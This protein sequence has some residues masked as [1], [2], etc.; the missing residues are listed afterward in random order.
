MKEEA[1]AARILYRD[2]D[3]LVIDKPAGLPVHPGPKTV[4]DLES[5]LPILRFDSRHVPALAH[6]LDTDTSGCLVLARSPKALKRLA[7]AFEAKTI[8][9]RYW[10]IVEGGP[11]EEAGR[12]DLP[13][14]K[15]NQVTGWR[16]VVD[17]DDGQKA[18]TLFRVLGRA[19][20][21]AWLELTPET[22]RTHQLRVHCT[23]MGYPIVGDPFYG[24]NVSTGARLHLMARR[25]EIPPLAEGRSP[26]SVEAPPPSH[27]VP[28]LRACG[29]VPDRTTG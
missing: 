20:G 23:A 25:I 5:L 21:K 4:R 26:V 3:I 11:E 22:G 15:H 27:M 8:G 14:A 18:V 6:R 28:L 19:D 10:A 16:M 17:R 9:K 29:W 12:I 1:L 24:R 7:R 2:A 13:L